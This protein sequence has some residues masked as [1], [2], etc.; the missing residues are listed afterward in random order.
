MTASFGGSPRPGHTAQ[1]SLSTFQTNAL[2]MALL[3]GRV[4][5]TDEF[6][7]HA[8]TL[9]KLT[10]KSS[11]EMAG[12][13]HAMAAL[14]MYGA[15][16]AIEEIEDALLR[17]RDGGYG[18]CQSCGQPNAFARLEVFPRRGVAPP[19]LRFQLALRARRRHTASDR[20]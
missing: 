5:Q 20:S 7:H 3:A 17:I 18:T 2:R 10:E 1:A 15:R 12:L 13:D 19:A 14:H 11:G 16:E 6:T 4:E 8:A 9:A